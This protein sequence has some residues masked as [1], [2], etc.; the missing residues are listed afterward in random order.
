MYSE[1]EEPLVCYGGIRAVLH[2]H[3]WQLLLVAYENVASYSPL[4]IYGQNVGLQNLGRF[5]YKRHLKIV[6]A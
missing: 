4:S 2:N 6:V 3:G 5:V 1:L